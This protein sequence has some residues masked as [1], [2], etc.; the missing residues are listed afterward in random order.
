MLYNVT[1]PLHLWRLNVS[2]MLLE[3]FKPGQAVNSSGTVEVAG[4]LV[5]LLHVNASNER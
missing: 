1:I 2:T 3:L 5:F 4:E